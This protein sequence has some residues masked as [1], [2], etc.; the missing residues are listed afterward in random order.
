MRIRAADTALAIAHYFRE[1]R[2]NVLLMLDS[3][4][5]LATSQR[6]IGLLIGEPPTARGYTPSVF[7]MMSRFLE[8]LGA[9]SRGT[10]SSIINVLVDGDDL[11]EPIS[12]AVR[13][14][15]D[16][17]IVLDRSLAQHGHFPAVNVSQSLSRVFLDITDKRHQAAARN[18]RD[19]LATYS[20]VEDLLRVGAYV[21][22]TSARIDRA[23]FLKT[24]IDGFLKQGIDER[25]AFEDTQQRMFQL[26]EQWGN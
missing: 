5:R 2:Q 11:D 21:K 17:H 24:A 19:A 7:Q 20:E 22:G 25:A 15:V 3:I 9:S 14:I 26:A 16:G 12:D 8:Q 13:S 23:I 1:R 18:I 4:T 6:E 10:I